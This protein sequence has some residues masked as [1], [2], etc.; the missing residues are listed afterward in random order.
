M[1]K[2]RINVFI[3]DNRKLTLQPNTKYVTYTVYAVS[4]FF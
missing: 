4:L 1:K 2:R 3:Y